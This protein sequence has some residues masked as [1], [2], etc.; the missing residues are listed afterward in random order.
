MCFTID[1]IERACG[2]LVLTEF[3][4]FVYC[5]KSCHCEFES[6]SNLEVH[7]LSEHQDDKGA[8]FVNGDVWTDNC[9]IEPTPI[10]CVATNAKLGQFG[11]DAEQSIERNVVELYVDYAKPLPI[12]LVNENFDDD[13]NGIETNIAKDEPAPEE[14]PLG[15]VNSEENFWHD[16]LGIGNKEANVSIHHGQSRVKVASEWK[17]VSVENELIE[18]VGHGSLQRADEV[19]IVQKRPRGRPP[20]LKRKEIEEK[21]C[22]PRGHPAGTKNKQTI[23]NEATKAMTPKWSFGGPRGPMNSNTLEI[24]NERFYCDMCPDLSFKHKSS[25]LKHM[26]RRHIR[27]DIAE[28]LKQCE[29]CH[30]FPRIS[31]EHHM[32]MKHSELRFKCD[33]CDAV[34]RH[35]TSRVIHMRK[36]TGEKPFICSICGKAFASNSR[37]FFHEKS[38]HRTTNKETNINEAIKAMTPKR[39]V[40]RPRGPMKPNKLENSN[41]RFYCDMCPDLSFKQ[42]QGLLR[43]MTRRHIR[44]DIAEKMKQ[45]EICHK[46]PRISYEHHMKI[47]HSELRFKCDICDAEF[48]HKMTQKIH[49]RKHSGEKPF[50]CTSCGKA[51]YSKSSCYAHEIVV[52]SK[53]KRHQCTYCDRSYSQRTL[54][55]N[56]INAAHTKERPYVCDICNK[57]FASRKSLNIHKATHEEP[58]QKCRYCDKMFIAKASRWRH[59]MVYH[60]KVVMVDGKF[61]NMYKK[62]HRMKMEM[63][64]KKDQ[65]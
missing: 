22:K 8:I 2:L 62:S 32:K 25:M 23:I 29:I 4:T 15:T 26:T 51:F 3:N 28:K 12:L 36:H 30:K 17:N 61:M 58:K 49:M 20:G 1:Q 38:M 24:S 54:L 19:S 40:G 43:H 44:K 35:N 10:D 5:C 50:M 59:E 46:F 39:P 63:L 11:L 31:Y 33:I 41:E 27:K 18:I 14:S 56:H 34:F 64:T 37:R 57:D 47:K 21:P 60:R 42:K 7:I 45:C 65:G 53:V 16:S 52:H 6:G 9:S 55:Q 13:I 48:K